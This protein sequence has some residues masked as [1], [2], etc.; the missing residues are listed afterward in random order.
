MKFTPFALCIFTLVIVSVKSDEE[1]HWNWKEI[2]LDSQNLVEHI[3]KDF[4]W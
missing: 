2:N 1:I 3:P 4:V